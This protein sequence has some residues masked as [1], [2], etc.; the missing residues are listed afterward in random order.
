MFNHYGK[1][2]T[3]QHLWEKF[4]S[5]W[6]KMESHIVIIT[7]D[8]FIFGQDVFILSNV[9]MCGCCRIFLLFSSHGSSREMEWEQAVIV[10]CTIVARK[11]ETVKNPGRFSLS[12]ILVST[13][14]VVYLYVR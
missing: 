2:S 1:A 5:A 9:V 10:L 3:Y 14:Y 6:E 8:S 11:M 4:G 12:Q 7:R 13:F